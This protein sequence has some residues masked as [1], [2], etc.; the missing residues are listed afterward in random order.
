MKKILVLSRCLVG[1]VEKWRD[2]KLF[3]LI[4]EKSE[5]MENVAY[6]KLL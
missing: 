3:Y 2:R 6:I 4:K 5:R 1:W